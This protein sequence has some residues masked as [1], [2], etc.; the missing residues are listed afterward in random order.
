MVFDWPIRKH[1]STIREVQIGATAAQGGTRA[2]AVNV[3]GATAMPFHHFDGALGRRPVVGMEV[4]DR[5]PERYPPPLREQFG[6]LLD[7]PVAMARRCVQEHGAELISVRLEGSDPLKGDSSP[8]DAAELVAS[9][10]E[11]V[12]VPVVVTGVGHFDK[13]N[14][15]MKRVAERCA[16]ERLLLN[17]VE[18]DNY[19]TIVAAALAYG[20]NVVTLSP[21]DINMAKQL[22]I[23]V[24]DMGLPPE[25]V[26]MD[27][28]MS[29][30]GYGLDYGYTICERVK[31]AG[32]GGD[33]M[34]AQPILLNVGFECAKIKELHAAEEQAELGA[35]EQRAPLWEI[36]TAT[37][38]L[39]AG[40]DILILYHPQSVAALRERI[41]DLF[42]ECAT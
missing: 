35:L 17:W 18:T 40:A 37:S 32:L 7:D 27:P 5:P 9:M 38:L 41:G 20:H 42:E 2:H 21:V 13:N 29:P 34:L 1:T 22:N 26:M 4:F 31:L 33:D 8:E 12:E 14:Q 11:A 15:V 6:E 16:G 28:M 30:L 36:V 24:R 25:R 23:L 39:L 19:K 10:L 3:G